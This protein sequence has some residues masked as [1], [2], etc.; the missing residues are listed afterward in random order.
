MK[1]Y[2]GLT[3]EQMIESLGEPHKTGHYEN[4][5]LDQ[6]IYLY[7]PEADF[8]PQKQVTYGFLNNSLVIISTGYDFQERLFKQYEL[9]HQSLIKGWGENLKVEPT[10][11]SSEDE[12][13]NIVTVWNKGNSE[14]VIFFSNDPSDPNLVVVQTYKSQEESG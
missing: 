12:D 1:E 14:I 7:P 9:Y 8:Q 6:I 11:P 13:K 4:N 3:K 5:N 2:W 10:R